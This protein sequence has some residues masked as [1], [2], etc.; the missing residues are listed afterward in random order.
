METKLTMGGRYTT[1]KEEEQIPYQAPQ[2]WKTHTRKTNPHNISFLKPEGLGSPVAQRF[3]VAFN[4]G[5]GPG[6]LGSSSSS[7]SP[8]AFGAWN[9]ACFSLYL[10]LCLCLSV[11]LSLRLMNK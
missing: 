4:L 9:G 2:A 1:E 8:S 5:Y 11:S 3:S 10:G 6:A 7:G